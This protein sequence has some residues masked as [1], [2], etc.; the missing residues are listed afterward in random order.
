MSLRYL[1]GPVAAHFADQNLHAARQAGACRAFNA[2]GA[3]VDLAVRPGDAWTA[4]EQSL[5]E[6]W[7]PDFVALWLP[8]TTVPAGL[9]SAPVPLVG[10]AADWNLNWHHYRH[11]LP[12]CELALT[13]VAGVETLARAGIRHARSANLFG[14][15]RALLEGP[16][17]TAPRDV[18]VLFVGN[19]H[20]AVQRER[21][22]WLL[23]LARLGQRWHVVV[24]TGA[25]GADYRA[26]LGRARIVFNRSV[27]GEANR[28]TFEAAA[29]G[30]LLF[31]EAGNREVPQ[32]FEPGTEYVAYGDHDLEALLEHYLTHEEERRAVAEAA[33]VRVREYGFAALWDWAL[34]TIEAEW[35]AMVSRA[36]QRPTPESAAALPART[37]Q[38]LGGGS[39][40]A[41]AADLMQALSAAPRSAALHNALGLALAMAGRKEGRTAAPQAEQAAPSFAHAQECDPG[42]IVAALNLAEALIGVRQMGP[43]MRVAR[44]ALETLERLPALGP[45][46]LD[47]GHFP[48]EF[49]YFRVEW[50]QAAW[51]HA[52]DPAAEERAKRALLRWRLHTLLADL[53]GE[54]FHFHEAVAA[55]D[56]LPTAQAALGCAWAR[57][58]LPADA[59]PRLRRAVDANPFDGAAARALCQA[60]RECGQAGEADRLAA[61]RRLLARVAPQAVPPEPWFA[62]VAPTAPPAAGGLASL[63]VLCHNELVYTRQCLESVLRHTRPPYELVLVDNGSSDGT[64]AY[65]DELRRRPGPERVVV[66]RNAENKGFPAGCNQGLAEAW[67]DSV[68]FLNNDTVVA[69]GWLDGLIRWTRSGGAKVGLVGAVSNYVAA[70]QQVDIDYTDPAGIDLFAARRRQAFAGQ[71]LEFPRLSGFCLLATREALRAVGGFDERFGIG[72]FDDDDLCLR[73][74]Q[75]GYRLLVALD[76]FVHHYGSRTF[77]ALGIDTERQLHENFERFQQK[78]GPAHAAPYRRPAESA[79]RAN[80]VTAADGAAAVARPL[81]P[82]AALNGQAR[83]SLCLIVKDE[84]DNLPD[85]LASAAD[86]FDE[87]VVVDTGSS[88]QTKAIAA[89][90]GAKVFD[91]P[92]VDSFAAA[93][94]ESL[95]HATGHWIFWLD[96]DDRLDGANREKLRA[97]LTG[98]ADENVAYA[99]KCLCLPAAGSGGPATTVDHVRLFRNRPDVRWEHRVHEQ[100]LP[101]VRRV[102][103]AVRWSDVVIHH[104]GYQDPALRGRKLERDLRLLHVEDAERPGHPFTLFNL[105]QVVQELGRPADA[106]PLLRRSLELS[107]PTDSIVRKLYAL[108]TQCHRRLGQVDRAQTACAE[109]RGHYPDD[110]ELL[111]LEGLLRKDAN[112]FVGAAAALERLVNGQSADHF[113]SVDAGLRGHKGRHHLALVYGQQGRAADAEAQFRAALAERPDFVPAWLGLAELL[114]AERRWDDLEAAASGLAAGS[115]AATEATVLRAR[116]RLARGDFGGARTLLDGAIAADPRALW[117]RV[118]RTHAL[119][120]EGKDLDA[121]E[122][123]L[124]DVLALDPEYREA[125]NNLA[126]L[127]RRREEAKLAAD[128]I[129]AGNVGLAELYYA[130]CREPSDIHEHLPRLVVLGRQCRHITELGTRTGV[131]ATAF[132][133]AQPDRLICYDRVRYPQ[134]DRLFLVAGRTDLVFHQRDVLWS[135]VEP[136]DLLFIDTLHDYDQLKQELALHAGKARKFIV[137]HDTTTFGATGET[138]GQQGLWPAVE[139]FLAAGTFRLKERYTNNNGLSVLERVAS[140]PSAP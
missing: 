106:L 109:G 86:L 101:A 10:L 100:I 95:R 113:A 123:A 38:A 110:G 42:H 1:F 111:F 71:A 81:G 20:P 51:A 33:R 126:I 4:I 7:R 2:T 98:L 39:D 18:D 97:L 87:V 45:D 13:D 89:R 47:A 137:L 94:N 125:R 12:R 66:V 17:P 37:W 40:P 49:D 136:T 74:R 9:W 34:T 117:P 16:W 44:R 52:G 131:S 134:I 41:L 59:V 135:E 64:P 115:G 122:R 53:T 60:L 30:A 88:D 22:P 112:D 29:A 26:L 130:A 5:P 6:G 14:C 73:V 124:R 65:L 69:A 121:A 54:L 21:L 75:A 108:I 36:G 58:G 57:A 28:R 105:G 80:E 132:L 24:R 103:A 50:E 104:T 35:E 31:Q 114:L 8:Y 119:L 116:S 77:R 118:I 84:E 127:L 76:V 90:C 139:E 19:L 128:A 55:R 68:V 62:E 85:C 91:F 15:E 129:F 23:R 133:Y 107:A 96:A 61:D 43:A 120:Q 46:V 25:W 32:Y 140:P 48:P 56:D 83:V 63:I 11:C 102:G 138:P 3:G 72:F 27:R 99:M 70:P 82:A 93:R 92:W 78:W 67:G 79:P